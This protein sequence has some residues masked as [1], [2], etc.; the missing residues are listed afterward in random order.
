MSSLNKLIEKLAGSNSSTVAE[1]DESAPIAQNATD[2]VYVEKLASAVDFIVDNIDTTFTEELSQKDKVSIIKEA[3]AR[4]PVTGRFVSDGNPTLTVPEQVA[5]EAPPEEPESNVT[6]ITGK[7]RDRLRARITAK[8]EAVAE[9]DQ[10]MED[11]KEEKQELLQS[12]LGKLKELKSD[13]SDQSD[14]DT[15]ED[16]ENFYSGSSDDP[17]SEEEIFNVGSTATDDTENSTDDN[18]DVDGE[19]AVKAASAGQSLAEVLNAAL[20]S[21]GQFD[22]SASTGAET[23]DVHGSEGPMA[24]KQATDSLKRKLLAK[25]G[26]EA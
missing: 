23:G 11:S 8:Q 9:E 13:K 1:T 20:S 19:M 14:A 26:K 25:I 24:R 17:V 4:D 7:L 5:E 22:E 15:P 12:V 18:S 2:P 10:K 21:D 3:I 6:D 16:S